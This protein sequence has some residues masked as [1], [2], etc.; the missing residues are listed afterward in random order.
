MPL[1][2]H[3]TQ[4]EEW[5]KATLMDDPRALSWDTIT[6]SRKSLNMILAI[7]LQCKVPHRVFGKA[8]L[9]P[10]L[11]QRL[12]HSSPRPK[13]NYPT[14]PWVMQL[15]NDTSE[16]LCLTYPL[17]ENLRDLIT[18]RICLRGKL[19]MRAWNQSLISPG[20]CPGPGNMLPK[21]KSEQRGDSAVPRPGWRSIYASV[22]VY[23]TKISPGPSIASCGGD[24]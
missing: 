10:P 14:H 22:K 4:S 24:C 7:L 21:G 3:C 23:S 9:R 2:S 17:L 1:G 5:V 8:W 20:V 16:I 6:T 19:G 11:H 15:L 12:Q 18:L 13:E